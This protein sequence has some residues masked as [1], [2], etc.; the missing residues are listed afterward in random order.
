MLKSCGNDAT[1]LAKWCVRTTW[2]RHRASHVT[3]PFTWAACKWMSEPLKQTMVDWAG[4]G[5]SVYFSFYK[6]HRL[7]YTSFLPMLPEKGYLY[8]TAFVVAKCRR[9]HFCMPLVLE[10]RSSPMGFVRSGAHQ[11][12][13]ISHPLCVHKSLALSTFQFGLC[14]LKLVRSQPFL[15]YIPPSQL[16]VQFYRVFKSSIVRCSDDSDGS[17]IWLVLVSGHVKRWTW[18]TVA[19]QPLCGT[20]KAAGRKFVDFS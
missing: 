12:K 19:E 14:S 2:Q 17:T 10:L 3:R 1:S 4:F 7:S 20:W 5:D 8:A 13:T 11:K 18:W 16:G 15:P 6:R 9:P